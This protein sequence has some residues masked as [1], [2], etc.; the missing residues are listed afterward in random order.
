MHTIPR[1]INPAANSLFG[2]QTSSS[3]L[4]GDVIKALTSELSELGDGAQLPEQCKASCEPL[5]TLAK[6]CSTSASES[7][8]NSTEACLKGFCQ[9][10]QIDNMVK[11]QDCIAENV[12]SAIDPEDKDGLAKLVEGL[13]TAC[14]ESGN[15][16]EG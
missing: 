7:D 3:S 9:K 6:S 10:D 11:C 14:K 1:L 8:D 13:K 15:P 5:S 4:Q 16:V 2:R 12:P